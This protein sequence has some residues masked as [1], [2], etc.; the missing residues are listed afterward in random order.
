[1]TDWRKVTGSQD[2]RPPEYDTQT[3]SVVVYQRRN[4]RRTGDMWEYDEREMTRDEYADMALEQN[5]ADIAYIAME[6]GVEL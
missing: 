2:T 5:R 6:A 1:M 3:S 4:I